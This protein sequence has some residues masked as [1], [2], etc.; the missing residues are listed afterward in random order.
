MHSSKEK[1]AGLLADMCKSCPRPTA[2]EIIGV[3]VI[4][5]ISRQQHVHE[6]GHEAI[7]RVRVQAGS[8]SSAQTQINAKLFASRIP[9]ETVEAKMA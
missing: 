4:M 7:P 1:S 5:F 2:T 6:C 8:M 3:S 9:A